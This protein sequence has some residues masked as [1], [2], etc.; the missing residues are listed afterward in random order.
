MQDWDLSPERYGR[1]YLCPTLM[2]FWETWPPRHR[3]DC[4]PWWQYPSQ[5]PQPTQPFSDLFSRPLSPRLGYHI[6]DLTNAFIHDYKRQTRPM[7]VF[8]SAGLNNILSGN[9]N[10]Q[11]HLHGRGQGHAKQLPFRYCYT[12]NFTKAR[13]LYWQLSYDEINSWISFFNTQS[14]RTYTPRF[15]RWCWQHDELPATP[16]QPVKA[17]LLIHLTTVRLIRGELDR[18]SALE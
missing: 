11:V 14:V 13:M 6:T 3:P 17:M 9:D 8:L 18:F 10:R 16:V 1:T 2:L 4:L 15:N 7:N 12:A 5:H